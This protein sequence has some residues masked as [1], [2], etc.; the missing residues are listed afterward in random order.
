LAELLAQFLADLLATLIVGVGL[1]ALISSVQAKRRKIEARVIATV[2]RS[3]GSLAIEFVL[4]NT[5]EVNFRE[6]EVFFHIWIAKH[7]EPLPNSSIDTAEV[8]IGKPYIRIRR[9]L[10]GPAFSQMPTV[11]ITIPV[12]ND[13]LGQRDLLYF[14]SLLTERFLAT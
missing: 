3:L 10:G 9:L 11:L 13:Q 1:T 2:Q 5:G 4:L 12:K 7:L 6:K 14:L 8:S